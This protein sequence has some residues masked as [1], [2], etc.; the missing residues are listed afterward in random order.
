MKPVRAGQEQLEPASEV[1]RTGQGLSFGGYI[2][3]GVAAGCR[4]SDRRDNSVNVTMHGRPL[5]I[6]KYHDGNS[7]PCQI[8]L[9][10]DVFVCG[11]EDVEARFFSHAQQGA[12]G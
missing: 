4:G 9:V 1:F 11:E 10:S 6:A 8:M 5:R 3:F 12:V 7:P 2:N